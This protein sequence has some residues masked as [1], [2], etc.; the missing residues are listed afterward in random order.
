M[1]YSRWPKVSSEHSRTYIHLDPSEALRLPGL[2]LL[3]Y[4][5]GPITPNPAVDWARLPDLP[6]EQLP[7][8]HTEHLALDIPVISSA[9]LSYSP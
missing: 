1:R 2:G 3:K 4:I 5:R 6:A 7:H 9:P 8:R